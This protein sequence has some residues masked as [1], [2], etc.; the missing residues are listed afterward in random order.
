MV[1]EFEDNYQSGFVLLYRSLSEKGYYR[2]S[3]YVH[4]WIH[5][6][7]KANH[8]GKEWMYKGSIFKVEPGQFITSRKRL[9]LDTG[10]N[11]S[12]IERILKC[13]ESEQQIEQQNMSVSRLISITNYA[14]Y[15]KR[16]QRVNNKRTASE[17][18]VNTNN[19]VKN[20]KNKNIPAREEFVSY[21]MS[22][23][24]DV[25]PMAAG[26]KYDAWVEDGWVDGNGKPIKNWRSKA[27]NTIPHLK[28]KQT[29][30]DKYRL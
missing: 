28:T 1:E 30:G 23:K 25:D 11:E 21:C 12:K 27:L 24:P 15:Q 13:F 17:Q 10:I 14:E 3:E 5:I 16:E 8:K 19:N 9:S 26:L 7:L 4:L 20:E 18:R 29:T 2:D 6:L 22:K